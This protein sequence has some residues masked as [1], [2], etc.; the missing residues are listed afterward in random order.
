MAEPEDPW[1]DAGDDLDVPS[2][3]GTSRD[4]HHERTN[5]HLIDVKAKLDNLRKTIESEGKHRRIEFAIQNAKMVTRDWIVG[6]GT[7]TLF[8]ANTDNLVQQILF[9][10]R[11]GNGYDIGKYFAFD[12]AGKPDH[13]N[14]STGYDK[15][16]IKLKHKLHLLLGQE[17]R[18]DTE[19]VEGGRTMVFY[20]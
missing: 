9:A 14:G 3:G 16:R 15:F 2:N 4:G 8:N 13:S 19:P 20:N 7:Q 18:I 6:Y 10:F 12:G 5:L 17:P 1:E 11:M